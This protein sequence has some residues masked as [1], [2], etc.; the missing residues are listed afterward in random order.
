MR[1]VWRGVAGVLCAGLFG[2]PVGCGDEVLVQPPPEPSLDA[3]LRRTLAGWGVIPIGAVP[4]QAPSLVELGRVLMFDRILSGNRDVSCGTCHHPTTHLSD[5]NALPVGT[6][7]SGLGPSRTLG[8]GRQYVP[9]SAP[10][11]LNGGLGLF[12]LFWDGRLQGFQ[13][14]PFTTADSVRLPAGLPNIL[15]AQAMLPVL[16]RR[17][18]RGDSG[19]LDVFGDLNEL[20]VYRDDQYVEIWRALMRRLLA[21]PEYA[22]MFGAAFPETP[23]AALGFQHAATAIAAFEIEAYT[24]TS[25]PLDRYLARDDAALTTEQKRGALLFFGRARCAQCHNGPLLG[26]GGVAN[27]GVPQH[28]PGTGSGAPL[29]FGF[30]DVVGQDFYRF[31]FRVA[32]LRNV[33]LTAPYFHNGAYPTLEAVVRHYNDVPVALRG[34]DVAQ[35]APALRGGYHGDDATIGAVLATLDGRLVA[36][37]G[38]TDEERRLVVA[39]LKSLTDP[40]A[41]DLRSLVPAVVPSGLPVDR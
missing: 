35:L 4:P 21:I 9:R 6:G 23:A 26:G 32:P 24:W 5:D 37:I 28:G 33:E 3:Q 1:S 12:Q 25:S 16:N 38:L 40:A 18:M 34:Y 41:R 7:G 22:A 8:P 17:E 30:G 20:A 31:A 27:V 13:A 29:D 2:L 19:D 11:L 39:F 14:G 36:P 10:S 15:A